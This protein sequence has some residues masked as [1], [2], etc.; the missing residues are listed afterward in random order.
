M[1][2]FVII[3]AIFV[4]LNMTSL[5]KAYMN[6]K[7]TTGW[8]RL[9]SKQIIK[10]KNTRICMFLW[11]F[12]RFHRCLWKVNTL[13]VIMKLLVLMQLALCDLCS[14]IKKFLF[15]M[16]NSDLPFK[17]QSN[18]INLEKGSVVAGDTEACQSIT[19]AKIIDSALNSTTF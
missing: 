18:M 7:L 10:Y 5:N 19:A 4:I 15:T 2:T 8:T 16:W 1:F 3:F 9:I 6:M 11:F 12:D 14:L 13:V 17:S